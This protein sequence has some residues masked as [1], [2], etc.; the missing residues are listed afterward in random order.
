MPTEINRVSRDFIS[1]CHRSRR[2]SRRRSPRSTRNTG[3]RLLSKLNDPDEFTR[4]N[5]NGTFARITTSKE[6]VDQVF[7]Y[8]LFQKF[9][10]I[11]ST[12][13]MN[14]QVLMLET[15]RNCIKSAKEGIMPL[16]ATSC[17]GLRVFTDI[18]KN[19][20][21]TDVKVMACE[22]IM[23]L[24][25]ERLTQFLQRMQSGCSQQ[26]HHQRRYKIV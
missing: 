7:K 17:N 12:E 10:E 19:S 9:I 8:N 21:V 13:K 22:C 23:M 24:W 20:L 14:I 3:N 15:C 2:N 5:L 16:A 6:G 18:A 1:P 4:Y 11:V 26:R 25:Y